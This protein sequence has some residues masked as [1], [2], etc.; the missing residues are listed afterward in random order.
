M[1]PLL[2]L[3]RAKQQ[4]IIPIIQTVTSAT[5]NK[6]P[7]C[8]TTAPACCSHARWIRGAKTNSRCFSVQHSCANCHRTPIPWRVMAIVLSSLA[9]RVRILV[10]G[11]VHGD[12]DEGDESAVEF[13][14]PDA[15]LFVGDFGEEHTELVGRV[16]AFAHRHPGR[17]AVLLGNHDAW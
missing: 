15:T 3:G 1:S 5:A 13:L 7:P 10:V 17:A 16:A 12:W 6:L 2:R 11:D 8:R 14:Q 4:E 9:G